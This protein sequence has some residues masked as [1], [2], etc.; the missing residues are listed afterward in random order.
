MKMTPFSRPV[1]KRKEMQYLAEIG[2][3]FLVYTFTDFSNAPSP[4]LEIIRDDRD[5]NATTTDYRSYVR[6]WQ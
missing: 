4:A 5:C 6:L 3:P 1:R 2:L